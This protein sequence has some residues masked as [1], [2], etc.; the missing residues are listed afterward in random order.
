MDYIAAFAE[1]GS[2]DI[3]FSAA[4]AGDSEPANDTLVRPLLV[5]P[6]YDASVSGSLMMSGLFGEQTRLQTF[7]VSTGPRALASARLLAGHALPA[8]RVQAIS[9]SVGD[10]HVDT[11]AGG[12]CDFTDLPAD[13]NVS[14][15]V[16]YHAAEG[17]AVVEPVISV[18]TPGDVFAANDSV[19]ARVETMGFT[20]VEL[21][22]TGT[23]AG[24]RSTSLGFPVI[25]IINGGNKAMTPRLEV[26]LPAG[27]GVDDVAASAG[28]CTGTSTLRCDFQTLEP[29]A[30][31]SVS[32]VVRASANGSFISNVKVITA[33]DV[34]PANDA[35]EVV[36]EINGTTVAASKEPG[37][38]G[39]RI[40]WLAL[41]L[42]AML[43][44]RKRIVASTRVA[45]SADA[46][47]R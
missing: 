12:I 4:A 16:T 29:F 11:D 47:S 6:Y 13:A 17:T 26:T 2:Y 34:N 45:R 31:A 10:C 32:L 46:V 37:G 24:P 36:L 41:A 15:S 30:R 1:P 27:V 35:G 25:E 18:S 38:G 28:I 39:G 20:D 22:V 44:A 23:V 8:L 42:L 43:V 9:A 5:L 7:T 40:E 3:A 21:R 33:N 14:V 19:T